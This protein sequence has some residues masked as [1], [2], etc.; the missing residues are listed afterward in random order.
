ML[1]VPA[2]IYFGGHAYFSDDARIA[3][4]A[5]D[6][7][8]GALLVLALLIVIEDIIRLTTVSFGV[9][10]RRVIVRKG[11]FKTRIQDMAIEDIT[12]SR[13][14]KCTWGRLF[15]F[16]AVTVSD[17]QTDLR[18]PTMVAPKI[19]RAKIE[20]A[21]ALATMQAETKTHDTGETRIDAAPSNDADAIAKRA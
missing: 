20:E 7:V 9:T 19:F 2:L 5:V 13:A 14:N 10:N 17:G 1:A 3:T 4:M 11:L 18:L 21:R 16:G 15:N 6:I 12:S 8:S